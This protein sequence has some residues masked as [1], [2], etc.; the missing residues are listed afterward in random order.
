MLNREILFFLLISFATI[1]TV[2]WLSLS[3]SKNL[4]E[5]FHCV[6]EEEQL[7]ATYPNTALAGLGASYA[8]LAL[9]PVFVPEQVCVAWEKDK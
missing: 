7:V 3:L 9:T 6:K 8:A 1:L 4:H 5:G 2:V